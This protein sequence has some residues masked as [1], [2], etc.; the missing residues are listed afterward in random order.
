MK[1]FLK[2]IRRIMEGLE[3]RNY[4]CVSIFGAYL[5]SLKHWDGYVTDPW[6]AYEQ[7]SRLK[8][9]HTKEFVQDIPKAINVLRSLMT[10]QKV[11]GVCICLNSFFWMSKI[12]SITI[13]DQYESVKDVLLPH[14]AI[15]SERKPEL[16]AE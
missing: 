9:N 7:Q 14:S 8:G 6:I 10:G 2:Y 13:I 12:V 11:N 5:R 15:N 1:V 16:V 3:C 4:R